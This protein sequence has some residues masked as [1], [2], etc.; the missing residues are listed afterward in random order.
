MKDLLRTDSVFTLDHE[1]YHVVFVDSVMGMGFVAPAD[2][3]LHEIQYSPAQ[4]A[5]TDEQGQEIA[6]ATPAQWLIYPAEDGHIHELVPYDRSEYK[7]KQSDEE[8][9]RE[10]VSLYQEWISL[11][12]SSREKAFESEEFYKG[13][14]WD[15]FQKGE[16]DRKARAAL[17]INKI[18]RNIDELAGH[19]RQQRTDIHY[20]PVEDSDQAGADIANIIA[21]QISYQC[22]FKREESAVFEDAA[23]TGRGIYNMYVDF[24][25]DLQGEVVIERY[26]WADVVFGPHEKNSL[27]DCEGLIK[28]KK[29]SLAKVK[30]LWSDKAESVE[31]D[32]T[33][34]MDPNDPASN[35]LHDSAGD[36]YAY[37]DN[38]KSPA[39]VGNYALIDIARKEI[40]VLECW[41]KEYLEVP[42]VVYA[43][44]SFYFNA[45]G[46]KK[47]DLDSVKSL[48]G[49]NI[50]PRKIT[51]YRI[52]KIAGNVLLS[53]EARADLPRQCYWT[54][55]VYAKKR[56]NDFWGKVEPAKDPQREINK[57]HSQA[58]DIGNKMCA[59]NWF[60]DDQTFAEGE[61]NKFKD[62]ATS[63]GSVF[64][65]LDVNHKPV[66]SEGVKF[67]SE[68]V[69]LLQLGDSELREMMNITVDPPGANTSAAEMLR[70]TKE[71]LTS[72]EYL[73]DNLSAAK[74]EIG[75][76]LLSVIKKYYPAQRILR[77]IKAAN[78]K[79]PV[80]IGSEDFS[81][82]TEERVKDI[83][84]ATDW[85][86][87]DV[88][89]T[90]SDESPSMR[91][92]TYA[93]LTDMQKSRAE[94]H[95]QKNQIVH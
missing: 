12:Q 65:V 35:R 53:D 58:V 88:I 81:N 66:A 1:H 87:L 20:L 32:F 47:A 51:T 92:A 57:R 27:K 68:I 17:T 14:Q 55:P 37:T 54:I 39:I 6:P 4:D 11:E 56:G 84:E 89:V 71:R 61:A 2:G 50:V 72:N 64:K 60:Y 78:S 80:K 45:Y 8:I 77:I 95:P 90:E 69:Q 26:P 22:D 48:P 30:Q 23:I 59:Y 82:I 34:Y 43:N 73:F 9:V 70:R 38:W 13:K 74:I 33:S 52:T 42:V 75:R 16:L 93:M 24:S 15:D 83:I 44:S 86:R 85:E 21:Q 41:R 94:H 28:R 36:A 79:S 18:E 25:E 67:P 76:R 19:Q 46:W 62:N 49:F 40:C 91:M 5:Q 7:S 10:V 31:A 3:H 29:I 63:P